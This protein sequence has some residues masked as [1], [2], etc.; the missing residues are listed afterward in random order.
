MIT[1]RR[2]MNKKGQAATELAIVLPIFM[3]LACGVVSIVYMSWQSLKT[4]QA[5]NLAARIEGQGRIA[6]GADDTA[7]NQGNGFHI[8]DG[9][10]S[11]ASDPNDLHPALQ[12][13]VFQEYYSAVSQM[14]N[15]GEQNNM[16]IKPPTSIGS[17]TDEVTIVRHFHPRLLFGFQVPDVQVTAKA[18]GGEDS[19]M[20]GLP[21]WQGFWNADA[22]HGGP[23]ATVIANKTDPHKPID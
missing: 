8:K 9:P 4:Q 2:M 14:F 18:Y 7:L 20:Y 1:M 11:A 12:G 3:A 10:H 6:G 19:N 22:R 17:Y 23:I 15:A 13:G 5:A 21:R 16:E